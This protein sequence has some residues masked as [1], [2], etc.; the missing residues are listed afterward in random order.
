MEINTDLVKKLIKDQFP[1]WSHLEIRP[2]KISGNDNRTFHLGEEMSVRLPSAA[3]YVAQ[4]EK[5]QKWLPYLA[6]ELALPIPAPLRKGHACEAYPWP[7]SINKWLVGETV[8][9]TTVTDLNQLAFDLG[10]FLNELQGIDPSDG[11]LA[12]EHNFFRGGSLTVYDEETR[13]AIAKNEERFNGPVLLEIWEHALMSKWTSAP[14]WVHGDVAPG[15]LLVQNGQ[16]CA[17]IDFGILGIGDPACDLVM[18]WTFFDDKSRV[19]F[20]NT[21]KLDEATWSR[22]RGWA[23]WKA[24]ITFDEFKQS[25]PVL[26]REACDIIHRIVEDYTREDMT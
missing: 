5:E 26:A 2:V 17:V 25:N 20:K 19:V 6:S 14:V 8:S 7:W 1:E 22:A 10:T 16:L 21:L 12:G 24:L 15:N 13:A 18:A 23:L 3:A 4:V 9:Q 11:P